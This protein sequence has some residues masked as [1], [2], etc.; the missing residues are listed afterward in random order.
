MSRR[1][2]REVASAASAAWAKVVCECGPAAFGRSF[3]VADLSRPNV[4]DRRTSQSK[5]GSVLRV[6]DRATSDLCDSRPRTFFGCGSLWK[7]VLVWKSLR[8]VH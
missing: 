6:R 2:R 1:T 8:S 5:N 3:Q 4:S 7:A